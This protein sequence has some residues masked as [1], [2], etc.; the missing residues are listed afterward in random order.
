MLQLVLSMCTSTD[1]FVINTSVLP[2]VASEA[3][4]TNQQQL[5]QSMSKWQIISA[6]CQAQDSQ[7]RVVASRIA[8]APRSAKALVSSCC[9][10]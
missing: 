4:L 5:M 3:T 6:F 7:L 1:V 2:R 8:S 10:N 9:I